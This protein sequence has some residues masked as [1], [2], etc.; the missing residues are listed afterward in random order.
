MTVRAYAVER[1]GGPVQVHTYDAAP[2]GPLDVLVAVTHCGVCR[3]DVGMVDDE[4]GISAYPVVAGHEAIGVVEAL[5]DGV[6]R[7]RLTVGQRVG[8]GAT[9]GSC[10]ACEW[11]LSGRQQLCPAKDNTAVRGDGGAFASHV[12]ATDWRHVY[13]IPDAIAS[14][15]AGPLLCAG[16][17]VFAPLV[18]QGIRPTD[19]VAVVGIGGLGHLAIQFLAAWGC[20]VTAVSSTP[21]KEADAR[22][23]GAHAFVATGGATGVPTGVPTGGG[24]GLAAVANS[25][26]HILSTVSADLPWDAYLATLRPH[27]TLCVLGVFD[28]TMT[29]SPLSLVP[30]ERRIVGGVTAPPAQTR[31]MLDFAA[32]HGIRPTVETFPAARLDEAL[33]HVRRGR[34]RYRAVVEF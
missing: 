14:E 1:A 29:L 18:R 34:A 16:T 33:E 20:H 31:Q 25:F 3:T 23:F 5:G 28:G 2:L 7:G 26:D 8:V 4:W 27:G 15:H 19:R 6:D 32:R 21:D 30:G 17:T 13:P 9:A 12:R 24:T 22:R 10:F 11:C